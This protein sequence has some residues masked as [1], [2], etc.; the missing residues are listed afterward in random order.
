MSSASQTQDQRIADALADAWPGEVPA[1]ALSRI[2]L[3]FCAR[4]FSL[5]RRG[6]I[7]AN[8]IERRADGTKHSF[9][10]LGEPPIARSKE[11][12]KAN[13]KSTAS[14][15]QLQEPSSLFGDIAPDRSYRE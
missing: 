5:R 7:I 13:C 12:R 3:Q 15:Q 9:Y 14:A 11:L 6:W 2:S 8:R 10:K 1:V 4:I